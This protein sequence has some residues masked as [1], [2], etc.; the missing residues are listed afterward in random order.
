MHEAVHTLST[1]FVLGHGGS[2]ERQSR[3]G[4]SE[5]QRVAP[6]QPAACHIQQDMLSGQCGGG[7]TLQFVDL[8][9]EPIC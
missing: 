3:H 8:V 2:H 4:R 9:T 6:L 7:G 1:F 5:V